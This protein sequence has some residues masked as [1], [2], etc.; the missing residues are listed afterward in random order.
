MDSQHNKQLA[1]RFFERFDANDI[2]GALALMSDDATWWLAGKPDRIP[3]VGLLDKASI[4][5]L[6]R[7]MTARLEDGLRMQVVGAIAEGDAV[8]LEVRSHGVLKNG[9]VYENEYHTLMRLRDG[10]IHEVRE[11]Y[12]SQHVFEVWYQP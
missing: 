2:D 8:A 3:G 6:F 12:D 5:R 10:L 4:A 1:A 11:Y 9:R 7:R